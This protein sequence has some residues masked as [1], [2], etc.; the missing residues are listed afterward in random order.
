MSNFSDTTE[1]NIINATLRA[2]AYPLPS[3]IYIALFTAAPGEADSPSDEAAYTGYAREDADAGGALGSGFTSPTN[4]VSSNNNELVFG[5][6]QD[7]GDAVITHM[8]ILDSASGPSNML[9]WAELTAPKTLQQ[10]DKIVFG[11]GSIQVTVD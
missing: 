9:Y 3:A 5:A 6:N 4:G 1:T 11:A 7:V 8:A 10:N 2:I